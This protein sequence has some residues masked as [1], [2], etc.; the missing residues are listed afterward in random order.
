MW[1]EVWKLVLLQLLLLEFRWVKGNAL[2]FS[3]VLKEEKKEGDEGYSFIF[4]IIKR[5]R[6][7]AYNY[8]NF[9]GQIF[10]FYFC[11]NR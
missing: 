4:A 7:G 5:Y 2:V 10:A 1:A 9:L 6:I 3:A 11:L 8:R